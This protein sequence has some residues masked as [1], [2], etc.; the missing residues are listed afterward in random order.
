MLSFPVMSDVEFDFILRAVLP[1]ADKDERE[2]EIT[3]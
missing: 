1:K 2:Y 3:I